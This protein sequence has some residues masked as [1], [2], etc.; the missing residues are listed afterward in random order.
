MVKKI[1]RFLW[2]L[3]WARELASGNEIVLLSYKKG[4]LKPNQWYSISVCHMPPD[5]YDEVII[6]QLEDVEE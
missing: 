1:R 6:S 4:T 3:R 2:Q 5:I